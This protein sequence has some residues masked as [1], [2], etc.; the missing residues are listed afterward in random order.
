MIKVAA[1][2][3]NLSVERRGEQ[4]APAPPPP[5]VLFLPVISVLDMM[6]VSLSLLLVSTIYT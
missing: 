3:C 2:S 1:Q 4:R 5:Y 6:F